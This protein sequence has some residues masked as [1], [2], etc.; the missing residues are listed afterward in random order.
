MTV[1]E[2]TKW[3]GK[4]IV[5]KDGRGKVT[6]ETK[7]FSDMALPNMLYAKVTRSKYPHALIKRISTEKAKTIPGVVAVLTHKDIP[8]LNAFG[9][10]TPDQPVLCF[11]KVRYLGDAVA[12]VAAESLEA[13]ERAA[14]SV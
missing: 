2:E 12:V 1:R 7:F 5:R 8:A 13:A 9:I 14:Q 11:D 3:V 10:L 6:G 4:S